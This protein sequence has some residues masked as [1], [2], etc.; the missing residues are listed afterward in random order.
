MKHSSL[1]GPE[2]EGEDDGTVEVRIKFKRELLRDANADLLA[3][4]VGA[5]VITAAKRFIEDEEK[6]AESPI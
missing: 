4:L 3:E 6:N 2:A 1:Y 5:D